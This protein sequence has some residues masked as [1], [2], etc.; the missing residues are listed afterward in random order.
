MEFIYLF[1]EL[2]ELMD[3]PTSSTVSLNSCFT[4]IKHSKLGL[5]QN[6]NYV[7]INSIKTRRKSENFV[8]S[9]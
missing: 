1:K 8:L 5:T 2:R 6:L 4:K 3:H 7:S 9:F